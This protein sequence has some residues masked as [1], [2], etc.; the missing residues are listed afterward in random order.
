MRCKQCEIEKTEPG[1]II[2]VSSTQKA[3]YYPNFFDSQGKEHSHNETPITD[4]FEC[5]SRHRW[6]TVH[7]AKCHCGWPSPQEELQIMRP[8]EAKVQKKFRRSDEKQ[9]D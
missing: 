4:I 5:S 1:K 9:E 7:L 6:N 8:G 3:A 2:R